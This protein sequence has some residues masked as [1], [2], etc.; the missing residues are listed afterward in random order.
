MSLR[1][2]CIAF[3]PLGSR[4]KLEI[5]PVNPPLHPIQ[6]WGYLGCTARGSLGMRMD[7]VSARCRLRLATS[8]LRRRRRAARGGAGCAAGHRRPQALPAGW[9][10]GGRGRWRVLMGSGAPAEDRGAKRA[11]FET[12]S[13]GMKTEVLTQLGLQSL[14][15]ASFAL[16]SLLSH[17]PQL[18]FHIFSFS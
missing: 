18:L 14:L 17:F 2:P 9:R 7:L 1:G 4:C 8:R 15:I 6:H 11:G 13:S 10:R 5:S 12:R 16:L 3:P